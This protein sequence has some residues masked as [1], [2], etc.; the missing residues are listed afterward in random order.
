MI[1]VIYAHK[2][3]T[4]KRPAYRFVL[5]FAFAGRNPGELSRAEVKM[6]L[7]SRH[8][9]RAIHVAVRKELTK[10]FKSRANAKK[11]REYKGQAFLSILQGV[12]PSVKL[13][14]A[15]KSFL[16]REMRISESV[17]GVSTLDAIRAAA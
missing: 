14:R 15:E 17:S 12:H 7:Q 6:L 3:A 5:G 10:H 16:L 8:A 1:T 2:P 9:S 13:D 11:S 4:A